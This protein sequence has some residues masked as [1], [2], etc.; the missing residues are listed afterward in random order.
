MRAAS[1][2]SSLRTTLHPMVHS[3][4][5]RRTWWE[6]LEPQWQT[7]FKEAVLG[8]YE[9][10]DAPTDTELEQ[11][12]N[13]SVF[14]FAGPSGAYP[15]MSIELTNLSGIRLMEQVEILIVTHH[16]IASLEDLAMLRRLKS[17]YA[18]NNVIQT[19]SGIE[20][21]TELEQL[22]V[23]S[24]RIEDL[25]PLSQLHNLREVYANDNALR[26]LEGLSQ[27][28]SRK[29]KQFYCLPN[30]SLPDQEVLRVNNDFG[31]RCRLRPGV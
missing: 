19:L 28:H 12:W 24:N 27:L 14:R 2:Y 30:T 10:D 29:L 6:R 7:A 26:S 31:I 13:T 15:N 25:Q 1:T 3:A 8:K 4:A 22:F 9:P 16:S 17:L 5:G 18:Y 23:Q 11:L 20:S 21:L